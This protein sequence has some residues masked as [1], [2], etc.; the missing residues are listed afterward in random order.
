MPK[1]LNTG[2]V[3]L[4]IG[5]GLMMMISVMVYSKHMNIPNPT[6]MYMHIFQTTQISFNIKYENSNTHNKW[7]IYHNKGNENT[8]SIIAEI[9]F[10]Y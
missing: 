2:F 1:E 3:S 9:T 10:I 8:V 4:G 6:L 5:F 7:S